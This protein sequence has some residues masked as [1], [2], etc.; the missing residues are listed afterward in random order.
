MTSTPN[1]TL[2][3]KMAAAAATTSSA[4]GAIPPAPRR[5]SKPAEAPTEQAETVLAEAALDQVL[6]VVEQ[7]AVQ[8][9][10]RT[11]ADPAPEAAAAPEKVKIVAEAV[12]INISDSAIISGAGT[13][14]LHEAARRAFKSNPVF[15]VAALQSGYTAE[16]SALSFEDTNR[17]QASAV[18]AYTARV[19]LLRTVHSKINALSCGHMKFDNWLKQ[20]AYGDYD[21]IMYG[22]YAATYPGE[23]EFDVNCRHCGKPN[24]VA[25][26]VGQLARIESDDVY[27]EIRKLLDP[28]TDFKGAIS[29]SLVGRKEQRRL[30][31]SGIVV[32]ISNSSIQDHLDGVHWYSRMQDPKT[33]MLPQEI[34]GADVTRSMTMFVTR[35]LIPHNNQYLEVVDHESRASYIGRL[36]S[37]DGTALQNAIAA[38]QTKLEVSYTLPAYHCAH[39]AKKNDDLALDFE[40]LL[41]FKLQATQ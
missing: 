17:I 27:A 39:C 15:K 7:P 9:E 37:V 32:E 40:A 22:L 2:Q 6:D 33:G 30:P 8:S 12:E 28:S 34:A 3:A 24:K 19:K 25:V 14:A 38:V 11:E 21:T 10:I 29:N 1:T 20:T 26:E 16:M 23:N 41:F 4:Q 36:S 5:I 18:D 31:E 13:L 35:L